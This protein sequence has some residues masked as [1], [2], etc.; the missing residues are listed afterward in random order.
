MRET[1]TARLP[2]PD[3][4]AA[5]RQ[6][7]AS[8]TEA[9]TSRGAEGIPSRSKGGNPA[10]VAKP[11]PDAQ[12]RGQDPC[13]EHRNRVGQP[14]HVDPVSPGHRKLAAR[15]KVEVRTRGGTL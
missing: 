4:E 1:R 9:A 13:V 8:K 12:R 5:R 11:G 2:G 7:T 6:P 14:Q 15:Q 10:F 3:S